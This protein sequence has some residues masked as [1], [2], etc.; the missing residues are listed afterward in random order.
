VQYSWGQ[1]SYAGLKSLGFT[2]VDF[3]TYPGMGHS[4]CQ[5]EINDLSTFLKSLKF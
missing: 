1:K 4:S 3:T 2:N 5:E